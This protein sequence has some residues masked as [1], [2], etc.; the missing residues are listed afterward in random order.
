MYKFV[1]KSSDEEFKSNFEEYFV[2]DSMLYYYLFTE[3]Y[4]MTDNRCKNSFWH[5]GKTETYRKLSNPIKELLPVYCELIDDNYVI[6]SDTEIDEN[7]TY[8]KKNILSR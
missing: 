1:V 8:Y 5:F 2:K 7:K 4:C 6:T 3:R